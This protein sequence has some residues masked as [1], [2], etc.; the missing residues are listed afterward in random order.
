MKGQTFSLVELMIVIAILSIL[1][2]VAV[3]AY[4]DY[5]VRARVGEMISMS[6]S[7]KLMVSEYRQSTGI[8]PSGANA[9]VRNTVAGLPAPSD[10][11]SKVVTSV[12]ITDDTGTITVSTTSGN[13]GIDK[14][15]TTKTITFVP[16]ISKPGSI[17]WD[18]RG[19]TLENKYR[20]ATCR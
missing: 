2:I 9:V 20:P 8:F 4:N 11:A 19:G 13:L 14:N 1:G 12:G 16:D 3:P 6:N 5:S 15:T 18:C 7:A 10:F 17:D